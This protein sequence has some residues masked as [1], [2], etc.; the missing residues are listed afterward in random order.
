M[1]IS[2]IF[3][4]QLC[5]MC[6]VE[7]LLLTLESASN[8]LELVLAP[9]LTTF[10]DRKM[11]GKRAALGLRT[12]CSTCILNF[13][14]K[15]FCQFSSSFP[16]QKNTWRD[17]M[18]RNGGKCMLDVLTLVLLLNF[19]ESLKAMSPCLQVLHLVPDTLRES[20]SNAKFVQLPKPKYWQVAKHKKLKWKWMKQKRGIKEKPWIHFVPIE[21]NAECFL[22]NRMFA[23]EFLRSCN[24]EVWERISSP[25]QGAARPGTLRHWAFHR[26]SAGSQQNLNRR[27][28][29]CRFLFEVNS[30]QTT[31][32]MWLL[33][34]QTSSPLDSSLFSL[35]SGKFR[36]CYFSQNPWKIKLKVLY[37]HKEWPEI[38]SGGIV[39]RISHSYVKVELSRAQK[40][41]ISQVQC[42]QGK[43]WGMS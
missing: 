11:L 26:L 32:W 13:G 9:A 14:S 36:T 5:G 15:A 4:R 30:H 41:S 23:F 31:C 6:Q 17:A 37:V 38:I 29:L 20:I 42:R 10:A 34:P 16:L 39:R 18:D 7:A 40:D 24:Q 43:P 8:N 25:R 22:T 19:N 3:H 12:W 27:F 1:V 2:S 35:P 21:L 33:E 28:F